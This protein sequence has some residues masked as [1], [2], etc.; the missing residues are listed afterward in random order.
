[1]PLIAMVTEVKEDSCIFVPGL[2]VIVR[3][4]LLLKCCHPDRQWQATSDSKL[5]SD[6]AATTSATK[7][8]VSA[9]SEWTR[10]ELMGAVNTLVRRSFAACCDDASTS[11]SQACRD[12]V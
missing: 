9:M 4:L 5:T 11:V 1:M 10:G 2:S 8:Q 12:H 3:Q 7:V 6:L